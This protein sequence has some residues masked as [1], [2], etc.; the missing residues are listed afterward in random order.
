[1]AKRGRKEV[2]GAKK[3]KPVKLGPKFAVEGGMLPT[4][5]CITLEGPGQKYVAVKKKSPWLC[6]AAT[7]VTCSKAPLHRTKLL[8]MFL[9]DLNAGPEEVSMGT[10]DKMESLCPKTSALAA[11][12]WPL[13]IKGRKKNSKKPQVE[14]SKVFTFKQTWNGHAQHDWRL[15]RKKGSDGVW[16][17]IDDVPLLIHYLHDERLAYG[18]PVEHD[19]EASSSDDDD[20]SSE[21]SENHAKSDGSS[22]QVTFDRRDLSW[23]AKVKGATTGIVHRL[24]KCVPMKD[25]DKKPFTPLEFEAKKMEIQ[26]ELQAWAEKK[27][28]E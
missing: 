15:W 23:Q 8:D 2:K 26:R 18:V 12:R 17:H 24:T 13:P 25:Q 22:I 14:F 10:E 19:V 7:G 27:Q 20:D 3:F 9:E 5:C 11:K 6:M 21:A 1:M 28:H 16:L 4:P